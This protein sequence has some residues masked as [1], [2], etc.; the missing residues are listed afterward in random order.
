MR[1][2]DDGNE[3]LVHVVLKMLGMLMMVDEGPIMEPPRGEHHRKYRPDV[4]SADGR[5]WCEAGVVH[6]RKLIDVGRR[7]CDRILVMKRGPNSAST[8]ASQLRGRIEVPVEIRGWEP[9]ELDRLADAIG[10]RNDVSLEPMDV[11][12][13]SWMDRWMDDADDRECHRLLL[14]GENYMLGCLLWRVP[15][16]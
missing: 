3:R 13:M 2:R 14:D 6:H 10:A 11:G 8:L 1:A 15:S 9:T 12:P 4:I 7:S 5:T 16:A